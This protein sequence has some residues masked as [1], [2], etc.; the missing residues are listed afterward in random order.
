MTWEGRGPD[1][2][3]GTRRAESRRERGQDLERFLHMF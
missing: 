1:R 2:L 3:T